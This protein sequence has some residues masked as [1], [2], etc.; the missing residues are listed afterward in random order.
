MGDLEDICNNPDTF[1]GGSDRLQPGQIMSPKIPPR[2]DGHMSFFTYEELVTDWL[3]ITTLDNDK[4]GPALK[5]QLAG[6]ALIHKYSLERDLLRS[7]EPGA[8]VEY[9]LKKS[10]T[11][12]PQG[13]CGNF[14]PSSILVHALTQR[15]I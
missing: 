15:T 9:F 10:S 1:Y 14:L 12:V 6:D 11:Q 13:S 8:G 2:F 7:S 4:Q 5:A 3:D